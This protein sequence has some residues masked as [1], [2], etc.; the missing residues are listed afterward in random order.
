MKKIENVEL[1]FLSLDDYQ[2]L[3]KAMIESYSSMPNSYWR[4]HQ[5]ESLINRFP[6]GQVVIKVNNQIAGCALS[7]I[8]DYSKI[9]KHHTYQAITG[10]YTFNTHTDD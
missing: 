4:E 8:V 5:I 6:D 7:I 3:K 2:E 10:D 1:A 9:E